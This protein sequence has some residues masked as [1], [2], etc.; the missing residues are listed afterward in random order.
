MAAVLSIE[1]DDPSAERMARFLDEAGIDYAEVVL[2]NA[3]P[4]YIHSGPTIDQL[5]LGAEPLRR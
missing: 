2:W 1:N 5:L 4:W 3:Y